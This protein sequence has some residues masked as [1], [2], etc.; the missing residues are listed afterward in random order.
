MISRKYF[1]LVYKDRKTNLNI[2]QI[3]KEYHLSKNED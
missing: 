3:I 2:R 1:I